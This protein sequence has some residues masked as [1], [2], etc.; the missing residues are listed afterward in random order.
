[1]PASS[2]VSILVCLACGAKS[3]EKESA[4]HAPLQLAPTRAHILVYMLELRR[5]YPKRELKIPTRV[6]Y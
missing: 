5:C 2:V 1:M 4:T 3:D 6:S